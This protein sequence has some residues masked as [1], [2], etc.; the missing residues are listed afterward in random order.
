MIPFHHR[1]L[2]PDRGLE[3]RSTRINSPPSSPGRL[4]WVGGAGKSRTYKAIRH[5][6][7]SRAISPVIAAPIKL[8][9]TE[10]SA[11]KKSSGQAHTRTAGSE[12][13]SPSP[14][15]LCPNVYTIRIVKERSIEAKKDP[16]GC[17]PTG[18]SY[19][20]VP[21]RFECRA[22]REN[23]REGLSH[24][25]PTN[26]GER[27]DTVKRAMR[28]HEVHAGQARATTRFDGGIGVPAPIG[29][30]SGPKL[31][32]EVIHSGRGVYVPNPVCQLL[33]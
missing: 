23:I 32:N 19:W 16:G 21:G 7:Y 30:G 14:E 17:E 22:F 6:V 5:P 11:S 29:G 1:A 33:K 8:M 12:C 27:I 28:G 15:R 4:I 10:Y 13:C 24:R 31:L 25:F 18:V 20:R 3:P 26:R 9:P 2:A